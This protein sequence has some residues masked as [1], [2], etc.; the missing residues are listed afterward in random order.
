MPL[1]T[2]QVHQ[3]YLEPRSGEGRLYVTMDQSIACILSN[4]AVTHGYNYYY[5]YFISRIIIIIIINNIFIKKKTSEW[6][7]LTIII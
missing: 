1:A 4:L 6:S 5:Y 2:V 7:S 3:Q